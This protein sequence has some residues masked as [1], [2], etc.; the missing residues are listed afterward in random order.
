ML[1]ANKELIKK[2]V[3]DEGEWSAPRLGWYTREENQPFSLYRRLGNALEQAWGLG[4]REQFLVPTRNRAPAIQSDACSYTDRA[5]PAHNQT[6]TQ[7]PNAFNVL[8]KTVTNQT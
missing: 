4:R 6:M 5:I 7:E 3:I 1:I 8:D 2:K